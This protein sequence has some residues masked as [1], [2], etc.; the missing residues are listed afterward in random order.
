MRLEWQKDAESPN[1]YNAESFRYRF[2]LLA[3][4]TGK[5]NLW[6]QSVDDKWGTKA[7]DTR[8]CRSIRHAER[9]AQRFEDSGKA[10][11]LR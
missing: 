7:I 3:T 11:R 1:R 6:V 8:S 4:T 10:R 9:L 5:A 2:I